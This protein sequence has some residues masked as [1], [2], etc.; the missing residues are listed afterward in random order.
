MLTIHRGVLPRDVDRTK[1]W[2]D[3]NDWLA[4]DNGFKATG[5]GEISRKTVVRV[6]LKLQQS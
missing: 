4:K 5:I 2:R 1:L 3:V 6:L